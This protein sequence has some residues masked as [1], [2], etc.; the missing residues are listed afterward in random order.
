MNFLSPWFLLGTLAIG[1]PILAHLLNRYQVKRTDWA[2]MRFLNRSVRVRSRQ[3]RLKD[4]LLLVLRCLAILLFCLALARPG[5]K[6][7]GGMWSRL[8][9]E[10]R[11]GV[12]IAVDASYSMQHGVDR[13][14]F[15]RAIQ[16]ADAIGEHIHPGDPVTLVM[17]A[18][19]HRVAVRNMAFDHQ[20]FRTVLEAQKPVPEK[21]DLESV[22]GRLSE[23]ADDI[24]AL[25]KEIYIITDVQARDWSAPS[26]PLHD[27]FEEL[28]QGASVFLVP[29]Q[30]EAD[31]L[32]V[33]GLEL[34]SGVLRRGT[35]ARYRVTVK[36]FGIKPTSNVRVIGRVEGNQIESKIIPLIGPGREESVSLFVPFHNSGAQR[37]SAELPEDALPEDNIR[38]TV[39]VVRDEVSV[40]CVD[41]SSGDAGSLI[42]A[43]LQARDHEAADENF[44]V[45]SVSWLALPSEDL[46]KV[47]V[48]VLADVPELT[49]QQAGRLEQFV[50]RGNGL[51]WF[52]GPNVDVANWNER[53]GRDD[54]GLLSARMGTVVHAGDAMGAGKPLEPGM[55]KHAVL[56][57]L[58]SLPED[59]LNETRFLKCV[60]LTPH[61]SSTV[62]LNLAAGDSPILLEHSLGRGHVFMFATSAD[63]AWNNMAATPVF[64]MLL[65]QMVTYLA[66]REFEKPKRVG[67]TLAL[68]YAAQ[69]DASDAVFE[70]PSGG[71]ITVPVRQH[72][73]QYVALLEQA[74]EAG[75]YVARVSVQAPGMPIA[76]NVDTA[77]SEVRCLPDADLSGALEETGITIAS[78]ENALLGAMDLARTGRSFWRL[79]MLAALLSLLLESLL[80]SRMEKKMSPAYSGSPATGNSGSQSVDKGHSEG[81]TGELDG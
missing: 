50:R 11:A 41:G 33:I 49:H 35:I 37:V 10:P 27:A 6:R 15:E 31:N 80:A 34:V 59:L 40:L 74:R 63:P 60:Q 76:V 43:A 4:I 70:S 56:R 58:Q 65:Q 54:A 39:S 5:T 78:T 46:N 7:A 18:G 28:G 8:A 2:A 32:A 68:W 9:G 23:L 47:D 57:P 29:V 3:L 79:F 55:P 61:A 45:R 21:L 25:Q 72:G 64:P 26:A 67:D 17:L 52:A 19:E 81:R 69:P 24:D 48:L 73:S 51:I 42:L 13:T 75:Y 16:Q 1:L 36:N 20:R 66:G 71:E 38:R 30:G 77:E 12:V 14:R 22:P 53:A 44:R 62:L